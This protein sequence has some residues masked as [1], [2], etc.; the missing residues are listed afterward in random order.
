MH[1]TKAYLQWSSMKGAKRAKEYARGV[2]E[3]LKGL[4]VKVEANEK[5]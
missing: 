5:P 3:C 2:E 4:A 1:P